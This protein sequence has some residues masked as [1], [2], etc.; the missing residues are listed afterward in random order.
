M[1]TALTILAIAALSMAAGAYY[2]WRRGAPT[3]QVVL[4]AL[5]AVV[6]LANLLIWTLPYASGEAP[7][8]KAE[9]LAK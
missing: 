9:A 4:M 1:N 2:L 5:V 8:D 6:M 7:V 3:K